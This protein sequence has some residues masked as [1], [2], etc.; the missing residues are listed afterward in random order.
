MVRCGSPCTWRAN[1]TFIRSKHEKISKRG[2][3][4]QTVRT[5][6]ITNALIKV[7]CRCINTVQKI[8]TQP[9]K[10]K[11]NSPVLSLV[12]EKKH[13]VLFRCSNV[14]EYGRHARSSCTSKSQEKSVIA[15]QSPAADAHR[16]ASQA[17]RYLRPVTNRE[18]WAQTGQDI[19]GGPI[20]GFHG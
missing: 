20:D 13:G 18:S 2:K 19:G 15:L 11:K 14:S 3:S 16:P 7:F 1:F 17:S 10:E 9:L 6:C 5:K 12:L 4:K 8:L